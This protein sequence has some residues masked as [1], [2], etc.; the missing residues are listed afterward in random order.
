[1]KPVV[2]VAEDDQEIREILLEGLRDDGFAASGVA[3]GA[4]L[5]QRVADRGADVLI[6]DIGLPD[7]DGRD[8]CQ[9]LRAAGLETPILFLTALDA[10]PD[11]IAAFRAG[12]DDY[13]AK[14]FALAEVVE[15]LRALLRRTSAATPT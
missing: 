14:P 4:A 15:R 7:A 2:V 13:V 8:V 12:G 6:V 9:A 5:M 11:R 10:L 3:T 1:M